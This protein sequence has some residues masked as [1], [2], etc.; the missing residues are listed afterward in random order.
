MVRIHVEES[1][2]GKHGE[3]GSMSMCPMASMCLGMAEERPSL[4]LPCC[5]V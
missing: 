5:Q 1:G 3:A 2:T 4:L